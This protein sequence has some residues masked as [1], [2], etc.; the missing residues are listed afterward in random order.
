MRY[1]LVLAA[2]AMPVIA[3]LSQRD[4]FGP[5]NG[6]ISAQYPTLL[7]AAGYAFSIWGL[8]FLLD[9]IVALRLAM[10]A[11]TDAGVARLHGPLTLGFGLTAAWMIV[12]SQQAFWLALAIIWVA[13][14]A[15]I[16]ACLRAA[17]APPPSPLQRAPERWALGL[18]AGWLSLAAFLNT[19]QVI[20]AHRLLPVQ[21]GML[22]WSIVLWLLA[23]ALLL[24]VNRRQ[25]AH[26]AYPAAAT[27]GLVGAVV[28]Q[29]RSEL[30]G[31]EVSAGIAAVLAA[32]VVG[33]TVWLRRR[34]ANGGAATGKA[35][36]ARSSP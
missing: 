35:A 22:P 23:G 1:A 14:G 27:W 2:L 30:A 29:S 20:V 28:Q 7:V 4:V 9:G 13:T 8:I 26:L 25:G 16:T 19:A 12:F 21:D 10:R 17:A 11:R 33:Q 31:S 5:D 34:A 15:L 18:H 32:L 3:F 24:V 6:T 36:Q